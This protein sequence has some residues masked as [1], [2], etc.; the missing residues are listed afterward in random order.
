M[1]KEDYGKKD[2]L[3]A[4]TIKGTRAHFKTRYKMSEFAGNFSHDKRFSKTNWL[5]RCQTSK[6]SEAHLIEGKC[7]IYSSIR[8]KYSN[9]VN[10]ED[11][12]AFFSDVLEERE[13]LDEEQRSNP[14]G[15]GDNTMN[16]ASGC[17]QLPASL[18][19]L[20]TS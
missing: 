13:R 10:E 19:S 1:D 17:L 16:D 18:G 11:L 15:E 9:L 14:S 6:E 20:R 12:V 7:Q 3:L 4:K 5:C 8:A 2:Y